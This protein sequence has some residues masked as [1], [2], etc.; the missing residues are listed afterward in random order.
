MKVNL[1]QDHEAQPLVNLFEEM[2]QTRRKESNYYTYNS[3]TDH[4]ESGW[5]TQPTWC[6]YLYNLRYN[7][8]PPDED[9]DF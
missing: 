5:T 7:F 6:R 4:S 8:C 9:T 3:L 2:T 1:N